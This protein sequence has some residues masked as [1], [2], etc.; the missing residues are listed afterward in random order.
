MKISNNQISIENYCDDVLFM[1]FIK[2]D[3]IGLIKLGGCAKKFAKLVDQTSLWKHKL[4]ID[5]PKSICDTG[6]Y[7]EWYRF[8][9]S[10]QMGWDSTS[11]AI[12]ANID[13]YIN[14]DIYYE[15]IDAEMDSIPMKDYIFQLVVKY[16]INIVSKCEEFCLQLNN[17]VDHFC[18]WQR[19]Q[20][21]IYIASCLKVKDSYE[22]CNNHMLMDTFQDYT[23]DCPCCRMYSNC[24]SKHNYKE[25]DE[26]YKYYDDWVKK[27]K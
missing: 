9:F 15:D 27:H 25:P 21:L 4:S 10:F 11:S 14:G 5:F 3:T 1:I 6:N 13:A 7:R 16:G 8:L 22:I 20:V 17:C 19:R 2:T 23:L 18:L 24:I 26:D 12:C